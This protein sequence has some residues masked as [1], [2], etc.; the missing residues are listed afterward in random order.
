MKK[1]C[2]LFVCTGNAC[3]SQM[4][5]GWAR[6]LAGD[7]VEVLSADVEAHGLNPRAVEAMREA[8]MDISTQTSDVLTD[9]MLAR[10]DWVI[11]LCADADA[12]C[13]VLPAHLKKLHWPFPD[14]A[15]ARGSDEEV[16]QAF[17]KVRDAIRDRVTAFLE[18]KGCFAAR[19]AP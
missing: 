8:G 5:E 14:P 3:C 11:T 12:R 10:A 7:A 1:P 15:K 17:R 9:A 4:A 16:M 6:A 2:I 19:T 13:P 18:D